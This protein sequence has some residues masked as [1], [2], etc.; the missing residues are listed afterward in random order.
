MSN[1]LH[2]ALRKHL[3]P[4]SGTII[5]GAPDALTARIVEAAGFPVV[6]VSG[7]GIANAY[8]GAPDLGLT[9][10]TEVAAH[11][12]AIREAVTVPLVVDA[13]TGFG[14]A[15]NLRRTVRLFEQAGASAMQLE[16]QVFP[17]RCGHFEGKKVVP[18]AEMVQKIKAAPTRATS[19][20]LIIARTDARAGGPRRALKRAARTARRARTSCSSRR[21]SRSRSSRDP[22]RGPRRSH[23]Q[24]RVWRQDADA[25]A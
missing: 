23:L 3:A 9:T 19:W 15:L 13:D 6:Y 22:R 1:P 11:V 12:A 18:T 5:P 10:S 16:D 14:N 8:L 21:R 20:L 17:K 7:A 24:H 25:P 2:D 4:G